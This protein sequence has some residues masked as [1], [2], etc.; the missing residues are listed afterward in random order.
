MTFAGSGSIPSLSNARPNVSR[1]SDRKVS[2]LAGIFHRSA[3][4]VGSAT[5]FSLSVFEL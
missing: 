2:L 4:L 5:L 3:I 1:A